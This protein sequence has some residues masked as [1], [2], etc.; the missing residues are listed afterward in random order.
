MQKNFFERRYHL[1]VVLSRLPS[2]T[3]MQQQHFNNSGMP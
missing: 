1:S 3:I 2:N